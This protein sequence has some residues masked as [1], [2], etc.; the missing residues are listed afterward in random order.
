MVFTVHPLVSWERGWFFVASSVRAQPGSRARDE[1]RQRKIQ[2]DL[3]EASCDSHRIADFT[4]F[5]P[6]QFGLKHPQWGLNH[7]KIRI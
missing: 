3:G 7:E 4:F 5:E 1:E 6:G 2:E